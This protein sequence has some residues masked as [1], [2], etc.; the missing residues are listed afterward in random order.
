[1]LLSVAALMLEVWI[2]CLMSGCSNQSK[3]RVKY[4]NADY[5]TQSE[6]YR[7]KWVGDDG[8]TR[9]VCVK[10]KQCKVTHIYDVP[11]G[12]PTYLVGLATMKEGKV[13]IG[14][15]WVDLHLRR[16]EVETT[17]GK[18]EAKLK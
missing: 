10:S 18:L 16:E 3:V 1:M 13:V 12:R 8:E 14:F 5:F 6:G 4:S 15:D 9:D 17:P 2:V 11:K 7:I